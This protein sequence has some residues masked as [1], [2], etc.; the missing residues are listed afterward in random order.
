MVIADG[1]INNSIEEGFKKK[2]I[3]VIK[4]KAYKGVYEAISFH[5]DIFFHHLG[6]SDIVYA[7]GTHEQTLSQLL[8][9]GFKLIKG[10]TTLS[11]KY[12]HNIAYNVARI[13]KLA[14]H[15]TKYTDTI[16]ANELE[17][18]K[19]RLIHVNQGYSKCMV[20]IV[21]EKSIIT[22]DKGIA[23]AAKDN[24]LEVLLIESAEKILLPGFDSGFIGGSTGLI[25]KNELAFSGNLETLNSSEKIFDFVRARNIKLVSLTYNSIYDIGSILPIRINP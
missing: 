9:Y 5:P 2:N 16:L 11:S 15:N 22:S 3:S 17:K 14:F 20:C 10:L 13:G 18:R 7:P 8:S 25:N 6:G 24:G 4:T 1:R 21:D 19:V 23:K 12:P